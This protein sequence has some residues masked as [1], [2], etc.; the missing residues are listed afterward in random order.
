MYICALI[1]MQTLSRNFTILNIAVDCGDL[2]DPENGQV[3]LTGITFGSKAIYTCNDGFELV[4]S[5]VRMCLA[6]GEWMGEAPV[7]ERKH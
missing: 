5:S 2:D 7:C 3:S 1:S 6:T 4:G